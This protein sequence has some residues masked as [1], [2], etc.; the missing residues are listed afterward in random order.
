MS[1]VFV[2][3]LDMSGSADLLADAKANV[4]CHPHDLREADVLVPLDRDHRANVPIR[5]AVAM[6]AITAMP[7]QARHT[8]EPAGESTP[9]NPSHQPIILTAHSSKDRLPA[10]I[11][12]D[13]HW[14]LDSD[15][16]CRQLAERPDG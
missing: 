9:T 2:V 14:T 12:P 7:H 4:R 5:N 13:T 10:P 3:G 1:D 11:C 6:I 8:G 15:H 16:S